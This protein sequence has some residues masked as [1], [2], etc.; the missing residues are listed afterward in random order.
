MVNFKEEIA[1][2]IGEQVPGLTP[3]EIADMIEVPQDEKMGDY[4]F[5]CFKPVSYTHL[6]LW[7][8]TRYR[9]IPS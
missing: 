5:P 6:A 3:A 7:D 1:K 2:L 9:H 4:A 8:A